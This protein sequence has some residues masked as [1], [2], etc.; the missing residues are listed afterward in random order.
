MSLPLWLGGYLALQKFGSEPTLTIDL[1]ASLS[2]RVL[3]ALKANPRTVELRSLAPHFY[4][5]AARSL[6][7]F[8]E[9]EIVDVLLDVNAPS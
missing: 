9:D 4:D 3:N 8:E 1:P 6:D 5:L 7:L 2:P